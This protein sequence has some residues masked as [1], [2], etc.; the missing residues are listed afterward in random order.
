ME[1]VGLRVRTVTVLTVSR[2]LSHVA[3]RV[4]VHLLI[5]AALR[6]GLRPARPSLNVCSQSQRELLITRFTSDCWG[7]VVK[8]L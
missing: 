4:P 7:H 3:H 2:L 8:V 1:H 6:T 5:K